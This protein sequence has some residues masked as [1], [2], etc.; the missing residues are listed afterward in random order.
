M[1]VGK[2]VEG[3]S[4]GAAADL[5]P[6]D[7]ID[8]DVALPVLVSAVMQSLELPFAR[9]ATFSVSGTATSA[10]NP[11]QWSDLFLKLDGP[12]LLR[13][14][15]PPR[16]TADKALLWL[17]E[18]T[19]L[20]EMPNSGLV[21]PIQ[22]RRLGAVRGQ[23]GSIAI[24]FAPGQSAYK[25]KLEEKTEQAAADSGDKASKPARRTVS[26]KAGSQGGVEVIVDIEP[27]VRVRVKR[28]AYS[29]GVAVKETSENVIL[30]RLETDLAGFID[31]NRG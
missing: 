8:E 12:E 25:S 31:R 15:L 17:D 28:C 9:N 14:G 4:D 21:T 16:I 22:R 27:E 10:P 18:W 2:V 23:G 24:W 30:R 7:S 5:S 1:R 26:T 19:Q 13:V 20:W 29:E 3:S 11:G 6:T